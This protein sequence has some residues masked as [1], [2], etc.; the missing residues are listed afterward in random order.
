[1]RKDRLPMTVMEKVY[2]GFGATVV[3]S[4]L[5]WI[6]LFRDSEKLAFHPSKIAKALAVYHEKYNHLPDDL[7]IFMSG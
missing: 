7:D 5:I 1:M 6:S 3:L 4:L 2:V